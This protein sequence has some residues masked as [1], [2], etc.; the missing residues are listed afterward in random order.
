MVFTTIAVVVMINV[1]HWVNRSEAMRAT[2]TW[3]SDL[4]DVYSG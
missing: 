1:K 4:M 2:D 3:C